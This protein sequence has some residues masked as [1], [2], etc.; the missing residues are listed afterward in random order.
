[1]KNK[2]KPLYLSLSKW[3]CGDDSEDNNCRMGKGGTMLLN[4][5]GYMCCL[6]QFERQLDP[7]SSILEM[8]FPRRTSTVHPLLVKLEPHR[9]NSDFSESAVAINDDAETTISEK[10]ISLEILAQFEGYRLV[11][12][13]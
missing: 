4:D 9:A 11:V 8:S 1:M 5:E 3:R 13:D 6:G 10:I 7:K 2:L 12:I